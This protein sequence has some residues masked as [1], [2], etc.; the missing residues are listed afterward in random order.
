MIV[1]CKNC[2]TRFSVDSELFKSVTSPRFH[3]SRCDHYFQLADGLAEEPES[4]EDRVEPQTTHVVE[5]SIDDE[6][7]F[8]EEFEAED[9][10]EQTL[11]SEA[12][13]ELDSSLNEGL[14]ST[15]WPARINSSSATIPSLAQS[16]LDESDVRPSWPSIEKT[17]TVPKSFDSNTSGTEQELPLDYSIQRKP[18]QPEVGFSQTVLSKTP[19]HAQN[20][21]SSQTW[22]KLGLLSIVPLCFTAG[23]YYLSKN[24]ENLPALAQNYLLLTPK[25]LPTVAPDGVEILALSSNSEVLDDGTEFI[26]VAGEIINGSPFPLN[27]AV[28][29]VK[30]FDKEGSNLLREAV[31]TSSKISDAESITSLSKEVLVEMQNDSRDG[32]P[33]LNEDGGRKKFRVVLFEAPKESSFY[34]ARVYSV[35]QSRKHLGLK[36]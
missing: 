23:L 10:E 18:P 31:S 5:D 6:E 3:C 7:N 26:E 32:A 24:I 28:V 11:F 30:L 2:E 34:S 20:S 21:S 25:D 8:R 17:S 1:Q 36:K 29:E 13:S 19:T 33:I 16:S 4:K 27:D 9:N 15:D 12:N 35:N 22:K 14:S